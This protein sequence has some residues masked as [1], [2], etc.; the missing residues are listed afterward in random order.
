VATL[1]PTDWLEL[2]SQVLTLPGDYQYDRLF[3]AKDD[4]TLSLLY[5]RYH[6]LTR[7]E[8]EA[9]VGKVQPVSVG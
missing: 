6:E 2:T 7:D 3:T 4:A 5:T 9:I 8:A 1:K